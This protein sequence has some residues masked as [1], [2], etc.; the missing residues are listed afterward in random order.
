MQ[1]KFAAFIS[2]AQRI[3]DPQ[4]NDIF[5]TYP[6]KLQKSRPLPATLEDAYGDG[7]LTIEAQSSGFYVL[8]IGNQ[9]YR[10]SVLWELEQIL[11][12]WSLS[13]GYNWQ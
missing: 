1:S 12:N 13:E 5:Y 10:N 2:S 8:I 6:D 4:S 9:A 11:F 7:W 3:C